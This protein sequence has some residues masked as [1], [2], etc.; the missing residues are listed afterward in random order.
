[1][2]HPLLLKKDAEHSINI[3]SAYIH[4]LMDAFSS[5]AIILGVLTMSFWKTYWLDPLLT[6]LIG[7]YVACT[8]LRK[9]TESSMKPFRFSYLSLSK[10]STF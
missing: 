2:G 8:F 6:V 4:L 9:A 7:L 5:L 3:R 10:P 1:M